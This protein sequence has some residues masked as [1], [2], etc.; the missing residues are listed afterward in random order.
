MP[1]E[2]ITF[3]L[4]LGGWWHQLG[5]DDQR[6]ATA[7]EGVS[8]GK[9]SGAVGTYTGLP[10]AVEKRVLTRLGLARDDSATQVV[11]RDRHAALLSAIAIS[12]ASLERFCTEMRHLQ[13]AEVGEASEPFAAAQKGSS[14]MPHKRNPIVAERVCGLARVL[15]GYAQVGIENVALWHER[16]ISHSSTE[17]IVL[18]DAFIAL[19]YMLD[20]FRWIVEGMVVDRERMAANVDAQRGLVASQQVLL[21]MAASGMPRD[22]AYRLVQEAAT[23]VRDGRAPHLAD[24]L[25]QHAEIAPLLGGRISELTSGR[26]ALR[27][28]D[29]LFDRLP[30]VSSPAATRS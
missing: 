9:L 10:P 18:P 26:A 4:K 5:R 24:A 17:R 16:D 14:A 7:L 2:T 11:Q 22:A 1:A 20:R 28:I 23:Q 6:L 3:G 12:G 27:H 25:E 8:V 19:D 29:D 30:R 15:R 13:R 21:A